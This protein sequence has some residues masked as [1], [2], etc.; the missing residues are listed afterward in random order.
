MRHRIAGKK[1]GRN[2]SHRKAMLRNMACSIIRSA[3]PETGSGQIFTT[4]PKASAVRG[5]CERLVTLAKR[6]RACESD[7]KGQLKAL[8]LKRIIYSR[9][10]DWEIVRLLVDV[11]AEKHATRNGGYLR[12][13]KLQGR[14]L[15]DG[16][17]RVVIGWVA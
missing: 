17:D 15:G 7:Q 6:V 3:Q 9:T 13:L 5:F 4:G 1:L 10:A 14:R 8:H 11:V 2:P 12:V 16:G